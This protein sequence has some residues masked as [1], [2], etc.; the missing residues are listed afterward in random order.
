VFSNWRQMV[1]VCSHLAIWIVA[2][3]PVMVE[4][5]RGW[6]ALQDDA[7]ISLRSYQVLSLHPPLVGQLSGSSIGSGHILYDPGPLQF[8]LLALPVHIDP[9]QGALWGAA[10]IFGLCLSLAVEA[11]WSTGRVVACGVVGLVVLDLAWLT[12]ALFA[13][14]TWNPYFAIPFVVTS[15][16]LAWIVATGSVGWWPVLALTASAAA[17]TEVFFAVLSVALVAVAPCVGVVRRRPE[18]LRWL[19]SG[20]AVL[21]VC[22][23]PAV[24]Q[25]LTTRPGNL[26]LLLTGRRSAS[27]GLSFGL[28]A[29]GFAGSPSPVWLTHDLTLSTAVHGGGS[30]GGAL[31]VVAMAIVAAVAWRA[32]RYDL[33][34]LAGLALLSS[35]CAV[36]TF[37]AIPSNLEAR[38]LYLDKMLWPIGVLVWSVVAWAVVELV[39]AG[40]RRTRSVEPRTAGSKKPATVMGAGLGITA[41]MA[42]LLGVLGIGELDAAARAQVVASE[43]HLVKSMATQI[44]AQTPPGRVVVTFRGRSNWFSRYPLGQGLAWR[45]TSDGWT[46]VLPAEFSTVSGIIYQKRPRWPAVEVTLD[47]DEATVV[48][49]H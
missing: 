44:E 39:G 1:R 32:R 18:R 36:V 48:R 5:Q 23:L 21:V 45:L 11:L 38:I 28:S 12:P 8:A 47:P 46:P 2:L 41:A 42:V 31:T 24:I 33:A 17:Q 20:T 49:F 22:W 37:G 34:T 10:V 43:V 19:V 27:Q 29:V 3:V 40:A 35:A 14:P 26:T 15:L 6:R 4:M 9:A 7:T 16:V 13:H 30:I 25:E